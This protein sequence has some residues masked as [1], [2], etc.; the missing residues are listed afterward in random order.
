[1]RKA[2]IV[3]GFILGLI[4]LVSC[5]EIDEFGLGKKTTFDEAMSMLAEIQTD[6][7]SIVSDKSCDGEGGC[8]VLTYG[9]KACGGPSAYIIYGNK[10]DEA[11]LIK[12]CNE[13][14]SLQSEVNRRFGLVSDCSILNVPEITCVGG[15]C[16]EVER[17]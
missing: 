3:L 15:Q 1:M 12:K 11:L 14:T 16:V 9:K 7:E 6:I 8:K 5:S 10:I 2:S 13:F 17:N 4:A